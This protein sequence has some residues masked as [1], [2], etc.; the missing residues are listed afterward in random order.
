MYAWGGFEKLMWFIKN[1]PN[2]KSWPKRFER[3]LFTTQS[4]VATFGYGR[5]PLRF[6]IRD[7]I[8]MKLLISPRYGEYLCEDLIKNKNRNVKSEE[9]Y[10]TIF[11][12]T[13]IQ[14]SGFSFQEYI[15]C[16][17]QI[18]ESWSYLT[19]EHFDEMLKDFKWAT[20]KDYRDWEGYAKQSGREEF[21][22]NQVDSISYKTD[23][24]QG[25]FNAR[26]NFIRL[27][28]ESKMGAIHFPD[29][30]EIPSSEQHFKTA[31][32]IYFN[33]E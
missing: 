20:T 23:F 9:I 25:A 22:G 19:E 32:P 33:A 12:R 30:A 10:N 26:M 6:K 13:E 31:N 2:G 1:L 21:I 17:P 16:S 29:T 4:P 15:I 8:K 7:D 28:T 18:I 27:L 3:S 5:V 24:S 14:S 11:V